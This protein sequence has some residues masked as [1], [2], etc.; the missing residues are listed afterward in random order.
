MGPILVKKSLEDG[1]ISQKWQKKKKKKN[2]FEV[3][4]PLEMGPDLFAKI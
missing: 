2:I 3:E 4:K 1:P